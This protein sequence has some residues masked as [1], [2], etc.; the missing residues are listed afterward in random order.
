MAFK[1]TEWAHQNMEIPEPVEAEAGVQYLSIQAAAFNED[2]GVYTIRFKSLSNEALID[3]WYRTIN[4]GDNGFI[5]PN[6]RSRQTLVTLGAALAGTPIGIPNPVDI[7]GGVV[8]ANVVLNPSKTNPDKKYTNIYS[9]EPVPEDLRPFA[10]IDQYF[11]PSES[12]DEIVGDEM[13]EDL[14]EGDE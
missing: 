10:T 4:S 2:T 8:M 5:T 14:V 12:A 1:I 13:T 7:V 11:T 9:Y 3:I 6:V